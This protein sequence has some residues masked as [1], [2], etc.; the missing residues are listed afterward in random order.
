M[1]LKV[2]RPEL[3]YAEITELALSM[4]VREKLHLAEELKRQGIKAAWDLIFRSLKPGQVSEE[5]I[6]K[7]SK[8]VRKKLNTRRNSAA[9]TRRH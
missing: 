2:D 3:S 7:V 5:E 4:P 1:T 8:Q 6:L 9:T